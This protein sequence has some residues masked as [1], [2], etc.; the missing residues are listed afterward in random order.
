[1]SAHQGSPLQPVA[2][3]RVLGLVVWLVLAMSCSGKPDGKAA[4]S[5]TSDGAAS[6]GGSKPL[7]ALVRAADWMGS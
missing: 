4:A 2:S 3:A 6:G 5:G 7:V 1:M